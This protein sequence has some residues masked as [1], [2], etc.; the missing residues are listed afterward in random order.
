[1]FDS[2][3]RSQRDA[4]SDHVCTVNRLGLLSENVV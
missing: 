3:E 4:G 2:P 1:M